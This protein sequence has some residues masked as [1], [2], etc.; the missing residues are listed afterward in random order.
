MSFTANLQ[1]IVEQNENGLLSKHQSWDRIELKSVANVTNGFAFKSKL[2]SKSEGVPII[3]IRD[4][5]KAEPKTFYTGETPEGYWVNHGDLLIGMDGDFNHST[6][7]SDCALLNQRVCRLDPNEELYDKR[8]LFYALGGYL[9]AINDYT[10]SITVKHLSSATIKKIPLPLPPLT[11]QK[12][13]ADKLDSLLAKVDACKARL[14]K[15]PEII[16]RFRQSVLVD[17]TSGWL[18]E[19]WRIGKKLDQWQ[20]CKLKD[21]IIGNP[22]NGFSPK[23]ADFET[24]IKSLTLTATTSGKFDGSHFKFIDSEIAEDSHLWLNY[25]DILIQR[26]NTIEYVGVSAVYYGESKKYIYP[27]LMMKCLPNEKSS[28]EFLHHCLLSKKVRDYFRNNATGT[29]GNMP[30]INQTVVKETPISLPPL[31]EQKEIVKR[32]EALFSV[33]DQMEEKLKRAQIGVK[34]LNA[35]ILA[36][37]FRGELVPQD[38][39]DEPV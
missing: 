22:R 29:A 35:S 12:R 31:E 26:G 20:E 18:T 16:K 38:P 37:A 23:P 25:G 17:A 13:I 21:L 3:R 9:K 36:K 6:W 19:D 32:V 2:F 10:S 8:L 30:K 28:S 1:D 11:E 14:D 27:D 4:I 34:K 5:L 15:V 24:S 39:N 7:K 33:A